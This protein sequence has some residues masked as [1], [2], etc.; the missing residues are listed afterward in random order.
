MILLDTHVVIWLALEPDKISKKATSAI[1]RSR[2]AG[3]G[4]QYPI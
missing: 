4:S 3:E 1:D 2:Q